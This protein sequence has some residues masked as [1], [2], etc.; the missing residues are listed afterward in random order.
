MYKLYIG[1]MLFPVPPGEIT[2]SVRG[3]NQQYVLINGDEINVLQQPLLTDFSMEVLLPNV[4]Y[5]FADYQGGFQKA[6]PYLAKIDELFHSKKPFF[7]KMTRSFPDGKV[8]FSRNQMVNI[9]CSMENYEI[10]EASEN[11][12]D[13]IVSMEFKLYRHFGTKTVSEVTT[14]T[15]TAGVTQIAVT[16]QRETLRAPDYK[17]YTV[18]PNETLFNIA[19]K[20]YGNG[21]RWTQLYKANQTMIDADNAKNGGMQAM[22]RAGQVLTIPRP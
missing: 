8:V 13:I 22:V 11:G 14:P 20:A 21:D 7:V 19:L 6:D 3:Q 4:Q 17:T 1:D 9:E 5:H 16:Q 15:P 10:L 12:F 2:Y 18:E